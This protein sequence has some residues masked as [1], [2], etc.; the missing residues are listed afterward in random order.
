[1][2]AFLTIFKKTKYKPEDFK[3]EDILG[4]KEFIMNEYKYVDKY[5]HIYKNLDRRRVDKELNVVE[6]EVNVTEK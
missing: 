5:P 4:F 2:N 3:P 6:N 1:M